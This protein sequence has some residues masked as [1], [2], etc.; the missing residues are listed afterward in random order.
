MPPSRLFTLVVLV[1]VPATATS[2]VTPAIVPLG[3]TLGPIDP[4]TGPVSLART[5]RVV[6]SR[7]GRGGFPRTPAY[8][9]PAYDPNCDCNSG[10]RPQP[11][12]E[13]PV[14]I[15]DSSELPAPLQRVV[16]LSHE[17]PATLV[18]EFPA[19]AE[20]WVDGVKSDAKPDRE[21]TLTSPPIKRD[22]KFTFQVRARWT[23][24][25][26]TYEVERSV[27]VPNGKRSRALVVGGTEVKE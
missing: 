6:P 17:L 1:G 9:Y 2:Q 15:E 19:A 21:W 18:M 4:R 10:Y 12:Y 7:P 5:A 24:G 26:K 11:R 22:E 23:A 25:G 16:E 14:F 8:R 13:P 27:T 3:Q 20:V